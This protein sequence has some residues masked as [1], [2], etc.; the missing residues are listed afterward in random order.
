MKYPKIFPEVEININLTGII[1]SSPRLSTPR[2][3]PFDITGK[4]HECKST[5]VELDFVIT[6]EGVIVYCTRFNGSRFVPFDSFFDLPGHCFF[7]IKNK[8][9]VFNIPYNSTSK[10]SVKK[11]LKCPPQLT[12]ETQPKAQ[13][14]EINSQTS[15][16]KNNILNSDSTTSTEATPQSITLKI[17]K[18]EI[19]EPSSHPLDSHPSQENIE[20][21]F[22]SLEAA[23]TGIP[24]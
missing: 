7:K 2:F 16:I 19:T 23:V 21:F 24:T 11:E 12:S 1:V 22:Q 4:C 20:E 6:K 5:E 18:Q 14:L 3:I 9:R 10:P 13:P 15:I 17:P 8:G